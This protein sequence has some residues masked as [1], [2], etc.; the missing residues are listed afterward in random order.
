ML[1]ELVFSCL[2]KIKRNSPTK[3]PKKLLLLTEK[4]TPKPAEVL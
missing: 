4:F 2:Y 3:V 1:P